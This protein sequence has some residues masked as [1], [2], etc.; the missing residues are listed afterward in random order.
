MCEHPLPAAFQQ[1]TVAKSTALDDER[2]DT[3]RAS[4]CDL[5]N[6]LVLTGSEGELNIVDRFEVREGATLPAICLKCGARHDLD[7]QTFQLQW[8]PVWSELAVG[9]M[10]GRILLRKTYRTS[11]FRGWLC[12]PC[13]SNARTA[14]WILLAVTAAMVACLFAAAVHQN[15]YTAG[16]TVTVLVVTLVALS[17][18]Q[19]KR[20]QAIRIEED[21]TM[22][23]SKVH[24]DVVT[25]MTARLPR[26]ARPW[27]EA[28]GPSPLRRIFGFLL[29]IVGGLVVIAGGI[30][31]AAMVGQDIRY[32]AA[33]AGGAAFGASM[34]VFGFKLAS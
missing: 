14:A 22:T 26:S 28:T 6:E 13:Q 29:L 30:F 11:W 31:T 9:G 2:T 17:D 21:G 23:L 27:Q 18:L 34:V 8:R 20:V 25:A 24:R 33:G 5:K 15:L 32:I 10:V 1:R 16:A 4:A 19:S 12:T 3:L 7:E